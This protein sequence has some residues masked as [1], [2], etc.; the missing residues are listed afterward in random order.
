MAEA[1]PIALYLSSGLVASILLALG[2]LMMK[3]R[4][5]ALPA[6]QGRGAPRAILAWIRDPVW[7]G[8]LGVETAGYA[9]YVLALAGAP[10]AMV[11]VMMQG[12]IAL[13]VLLAVVFLGERARASEWL[14]VGGIVAAILMLGGSLGAGAAEAMVDARAL[15]ALSAVAVALA[16][17]PLGTRRLKASGA[18]VAIASGIAFGLGSLYTKALTETFLAQAGAA[19]ASRLATNP[20]LYLMIAANVV[21]L[22]MLQNSFHWARGIIAM[23][24]SSAASNVVPIAGGMV[25]FGEHLPGDPVAAAMRL[26]AFVITIIAGAILAAAQEPGSLRLSP[27]STGGGFVSQK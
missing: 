27:G 25:A 21:G 22:V 4:G 10:V 7:V 13:F 20:Y 16:L 9:L 11:A 24:L 6:A 15:G 5:E 12:G 19:I 18:A 8:G 26:G 23:P 14:G 17:A 3:S 2:L 1:A